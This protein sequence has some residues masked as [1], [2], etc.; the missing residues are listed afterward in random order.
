MKEER[1]SEDNLKKGSK[2]LLNV[3]LVVLTW[4]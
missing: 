1:K 4:F 3:D 2:T